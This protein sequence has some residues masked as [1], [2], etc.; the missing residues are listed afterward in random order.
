MAVRRLAMEDQRWTPNELWA[1][2]SSVY[3]KV[4][5]D[6]IQMATRD[7]MFRRKRHLLLTGLDPDLVM[8]SP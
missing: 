5:E 6:S 7:W 1:R 4:G 8:K 3:R 2:V